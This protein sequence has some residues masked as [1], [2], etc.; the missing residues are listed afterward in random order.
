MVVTLAG[1]LTA[2]AAPF[3]ATVSGVVCD[4]RGTPQMGAMVELMAANATVVARA[5]TNVHG[6]FTFAQVFPGTYQVKATGDSFLPTLREGLHL[7]S[8]SKVVVNLTLSTL[9]EAMQWLPAQPRSPDEP[10]DDWK[11]TLR[12]ST[13]RPLLR[14]LQDGPL[15]VLSGDDHGSAPQLAA[16]VAVQTSS[17]DFAQAGPHH[18]FAIERS[19]A[20]GGHLILRASLSP[21]PVN[22]SEYTAG[23]ELAL[24]PERQIY[25]VATVQQMSEIEG[26]GGSRGLS[27]LHRRSAEA[28]NLGPN[29]SLEV[30]NEVQSVRGAAET[31]TSSLPF[32]NA[33]WHDD[34]RRISY[35]LATSPEMQ[36][37]G[38][39]ADSTTLQ[40]MFSE[41]DGRVRMQRGLHQELRLEDDTASRRTLVAFY[42]D[43]VQNPVIAGG[44]WVSQQ[45]LAGGDML[46]DPVGQGFRVTGH[47]YTT[48]GIRASLEQKVGGTWATVSYVE[49]KAL[50]FDSPESTVTL[51]EAV[52]GIT[53]RKTQAIT[54]S[55]DGRVAHTGTSWRISYRWQPLD[56]VT[57]V[58]VYDSFGQG[59][60]LNLLIRQPVHC[61]H[62]LPNGTEA[63]VDVRNLLAQGYRPFV[64]RDG[65]TLYFA[66]TER[67]I[68]GGLSFTF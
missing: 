59:A 66:Q 46:Y 53:Q 65:S 35:R 3:P 36:N 50:A 47:G 42:Q 31:S 32:V 12:S 43:E 63:L 52:Q 4:G 20:V 13:N 40:P 19:S 22:S 28:V 56:T 14:L 55:L 38:D 16:R 68:Q 62:L 26:A 6:A 49:G 17:H 30:G 25:N 5:Y 60:Y 29:A 24:G 51:D 2:S 45:D 18:A 41:Q 61:G 44:G 23:Y 7:R 37:A 48:G 10:S 11:W 58:A 21:Q 27:A 54:A 39:M 1:L 57:P 15:V 67:S 33:V 34:R 64:T 9:F 8:R